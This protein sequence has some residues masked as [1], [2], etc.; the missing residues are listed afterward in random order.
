MKKL[1]LSTFLIFL[2]INSFAGHER[3]SLVISYKPVSGQPLKYEVSVKAV[4]DGSGFSVPPPSA[5]NMQISSSC[6]SNFTSSLPRINSSGNPTPILGADYCTTT[7]GM[8]YSALA[9]YKG[10]ITL[11]SHCA[12]VTI[13]TSSG[14]GRFDGTQNIQSFYDTPYFYAKL[15]TTTG[16]N[17]S[18]EVSITDLAQAMCLNKNV[19]L[20]GFTDVDGDSLYF[21]KTTPPKNATTNFNWQ[22]GYNQNNPL[23]TGSTYNLNSVTGK[24][25]ANIANVGNYIIP[26]KY[27]EYR[28]DPSS[29]S[30]VLVGEGVF[31]FG[32]TGTNTC[33]SPTSINIQY[34]SIPFSDSVHCGSD[35]IRFIAS[36]QIARS[37]LSLSGSEFEV[38]SLTQGN[39]TVQSASL[40]QDSI[41]EVTLS[42]VPPLNDIL[43]LTAKVGADGNVIIS[44]CGVELTANEDT[45][46][47]YTPSGAQPS[48][49]VSATH[50]FLNTSFNSTASV[51]DSAWWDF[52]DGNGSS[53]SA[54]NY[55]YSAPGSYTISFTAYGACG[56]TDDTTFTIQICDSIDAGFSY[57]QSGDTIFFDADLLVSGAA[58]HWDFGDGQTG[59]G[60][61]VWHIYAPGSGYL[62]EL[63]VGNI[64]GDTLAFSDTITTCEEP[65]PSWTYKVISTTAAGMTVDFDGTA[66]TNVNSFVW[67]FG[68]GTTDNSSLTPRHIYQTPGLHYYVSLTVENSCQQTRVRGF[69]MNEIG[70]GEYQL[71]TVYELYPNPTEDVLNIELAE[72]E[73]YLKSIELYSN[74][75]QLLIQ[76]K[77]ADKTNSTQINLK[78]LPSGQYILV[79]KSQSGAIIQKVITKD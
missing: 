29:S 31:I 20:Y 55:N 77:C 35:K 17:N 22:T 64:C 46:Y 48:A 50:Q 40:I 18:P 62:A 45:L 60:Q 34:E 72:K 75:G 44:R 24:V 79:L 70:L 52:G 53:Q 66:S 42:Q 58:Y 54:G 8:F 4:F 32:L 11:P 73:N 2:F 3:G 67:D 9:E 36:R 59:S 43:R 78:D 5:I 19:S 30:M 15:N 26:I 23:G 68:D 37:T 69:K 14:A 65:L 12:S 13:S 16:G 27:R 7:S 28:M 56:S 63:T 39:L 57:S 61:S 33:T 25:T 10:V 1:I 74:A 21:S 51:S 49:V 38:V 6:F 41:I 71:K 76:E 47:Y